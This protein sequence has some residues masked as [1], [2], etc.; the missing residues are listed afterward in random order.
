MKTGLTV[1]SLFDGISCGKI[2][3]DKAGIAINK[4]FASEVKQS[5]IKVS[6]KNNPTIIQI[7]DVNK[8]SYKD[9][10]LFTENGNY[11]VGKIDIIIGGSPC[12]DFSQAHRNRE[13]DKGVKSRLFYEYVRL[14]KEVEPTYFL[15]ENVV[16]LKEHEKIVTTTLGV[17]P[18]V[19]DSKLFTG[20]LR[21]RQYWTNI[22]FDKHIVDKG[23]T[24]QSVLSDGYTDREKARTLLESDSR[25]LKT[26]VKMYH[27]YQKFL[28]LVFKDKC[29]YLRCKQHYDNNFKGK[30]ASYI[31][32]FLGR[33]ELSVY[34]GIRLLNRTERELLQGVPVGYCDGL[35]SNEAAGVLGDGWTVDVIKH[36]FSFMEL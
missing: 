3:L 12:Q 28:T 23:I 32:G 26:P 4:Y 13:G 24:L 8:I 30:S 11:D 33:D 22:E 34:D 5:A 17:A 36:I 27:R 31:D 18:I 16:M 20:G 14:L 35:G 1:L 29:H 25:P 10:M 7:G 15:L 21:K 19:I 2:A 9:G 6:K